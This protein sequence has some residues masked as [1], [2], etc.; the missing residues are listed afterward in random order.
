M[1]N[2]NE[3]EMTSKE[4]AINKAIDHL[5][6]LTKEDFRGYR[7]EIWSCLAELYRDGFLDGKEDVWNHFPKTI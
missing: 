3:T 7:S 5:K 6:E 2:G 1:A 4:T